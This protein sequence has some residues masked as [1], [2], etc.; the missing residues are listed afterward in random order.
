MSPNDTLHLPVTVTRLLLP[1]LAPN[2]PLD[3]VDG[4]LLGVELRESTGRSYSP[5]HS[6][7][8]VALG[9][10]V[11]DQGGKGMLDWIGCVDWEFGCR[12]AMSD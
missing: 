12:T 1:V 3:A 9:Y 7:P 11:F 2:L 8:L 5:W 6:S 4:L 10:P